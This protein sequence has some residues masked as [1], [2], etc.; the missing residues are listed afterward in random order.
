M[1]MFL[2]NSSS[3]S[4]DVCVRL[5]RMRVLAAPPRSEKH[6]CVCR[7]SQSYPCLPKPPAGA[8]LLDV[9]SHFGRRRRWLN[10]GRQRRALL[11][12]LV[13]TA[14]PGFHDLMMV[15]WQRRRPRRR[16][17]H[18]QRSSISATAI[19][20]AM[21]YP[22]GRLQRNT[23]RPHGGASTPRPGCLDRSRSCKSRLTV[24][25]RTNGGAPPTPM[26]SMPPWP[27]E[28]AHLR[29][30]GSARCFLRC[31]RRGAAPPSPL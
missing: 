17:Q 28:H 18:Q 14:P 6:F 13:R 30:W 5:V 9:A 15:R 12:M 8:L 7:G 26:A 22:Y 10:S 16:P 3:A 23:T 21:A 4:A 2:P 25:S 29:C 19:T 11:R 27:T 1:Y 20:R 24:S 31:T